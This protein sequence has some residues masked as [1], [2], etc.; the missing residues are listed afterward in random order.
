MA[1]PEDVTLPTQDPAYPTVTAKVDIDGVSKSEDRDGTLRRT[2]VYQVWDQLSGAGVKTVMKAGHLSDLFMDALKGVT[3]PIVFTSFNWNA[4]RQAHRYPGNERLVCVDVKGEPFGPRGPGNKLV[5]TNFV[6]I[7]ATYESVPYTLS[8][9]SPSGDPYDPT[10]GSLGGVA[11]PYVSVRTSQG[12]REETIPLS[13][14]KS[15]FDANSTF[16]RG[17]KKSKY[18]LTYHLTYHKVPFLGREWNILLRDSVNNAPIWG[19]P[20]E[21]LRYDGAVA[22]PT[23]IGGGIPGYDVTVDLIEDPDGWNGMLPVGKDEAEQ[24]VFQ[25]AP[26]KNPYRLADFSVLVLSP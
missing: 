9:I 21:T 8:A 7:W 3:A 17:F 20:A 13:N 1:F 19:F 2:V 22:D 25:S 23:N 24:V 4:Y 12:V 18:I 16:S 15:G 10:V 5:E 11:M 14:I 26:T 6:R